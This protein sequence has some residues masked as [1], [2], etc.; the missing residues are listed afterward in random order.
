MNNTIMWSTPRQ[1]WKKWHAFV[2]VS[3]QSKPRGN[4]AVELCNNYAFI[5][6]NSVWNYEGLFLL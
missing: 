6:N 1:I 2:E 3:I 4:Y 5:F